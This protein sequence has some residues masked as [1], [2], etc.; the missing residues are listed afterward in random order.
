MS[1][2]MCDFCP[3]AGRA[4]VWYYPCDSFV[5]TIEFISN[6]AVTSR[7]CDST[8]GWMACD[9]CHEMIEAS[10]WDELLDRFVASSTLPDAPDDVQQT[11]R[12]GLRPVIETR[13]QGFREFRTGDAVGVVA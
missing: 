3:V 10:Q 5:T 6:E 8:A 7:D 4:A 11:F 9:A 1:A 12:D 13:W 2:P